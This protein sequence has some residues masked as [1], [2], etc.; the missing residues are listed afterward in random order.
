MA[1]IYIKSMEMPECCDECFA[2]DDNGDYPLCLVTGEQRGYT[3]RVRELRMPR[4]P[5]VEVP[6][7]GR[8]IDVDAME[9]LMSDTVQGDIRDYPY[10]DTLWDAAFR[11]L[12]NQP[13]IIPAEEDNNG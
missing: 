13:T 12:D 10:S 1:G 5:L 11:W 6:A 3:F 2:L 4:C 8:V 9:R 7:H